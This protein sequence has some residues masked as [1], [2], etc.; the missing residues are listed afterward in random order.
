MPVLTA[1]S[2]GGKLVGGTAAPA[3]PCRGCGGLKLESPRPYSQLDTD[4]VQTA[5]A[6]LRKMY[7]DAPILLAGFS[8][9]AMLVTKYLAEARSYSAASGG[10]LTCVEDPGWTCSTLGQ[11][12]SLAVCRLTDVSAKGQIKRATQ[13]LGVWDS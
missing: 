11:I 8:M 3:W 2:A 9:G 6:G 4:D 10:D 13:A 1:T 12:I 5:I 7:P